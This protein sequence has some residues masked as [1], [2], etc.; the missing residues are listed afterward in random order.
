MNRL[1]RNLVEYCMTALRSTCTPIG[2]VDATGGPAAAVLG[3]FRIIVGALFFLHGM[4]GLFGVPADPR[5][6]ATATFLEWPS[7]WAG[8]IQLVAGGLV[9]VGF[10]TRIA[11]LLCSGSMAYAFLFVHLKKGILP[12]ENGGE[13]AVLFCWSFFV[14]AVLGSGAFALRRSGSLSAWRVRG[15]DAP[16][17]PNDA[18]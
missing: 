8:M 3:C 12:I 18:L 11:A 13:P 1:A 6:G 17:G 4:S 7:W 10:G 16:V 9:A 2:T 5:G 14:L 15:A